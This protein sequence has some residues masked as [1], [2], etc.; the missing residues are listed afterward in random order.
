MADWLLDV[1]SLTRTLL[2]KLQH[3]LAVRLR[4]QSVLLFAIV[5]L[6]LATLSL[7]ESFKHTSP[8]A[9]CASRLTTTY[10]CPRP[11][12]SSLGPVPAAGT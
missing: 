6:A 3:M 10:R 1:R 11:C 12:S 5:L 7:S 4:H 2:V 8:A 9:G